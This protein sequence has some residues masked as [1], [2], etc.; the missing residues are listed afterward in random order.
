LFALHKG[1][2]AHA[3][4]FV[5]GVV[6]LSIDLTSQSARFLLPVFPLALAL[7][8]VGVA[9]VFRR[10]WR[11]MQ[12]A[13]A[14]TLLLAL[15]FGLGSETLYAL[16]FLPVVVGL[17]KREAF[18][19]RMAHDYG[20]VSFINR[21]LE[22]RP[23]KVMVF[24]QPV[25]YLRIPFLTGDPM[26]AWPMDPDRLKGPQALLQLFRQQNVRWVVKAPDY[27]EPFAPALQ[28]LEDEGKLRPKF[29]ADSSSFDGY[30]ICGERVPVHAVIMEVATAP[31]CPES[32]VS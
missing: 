31:E 24:F 27:P 21:S 15:L 18:L 16:D 12:L 8:F 7:I 17:E 23:G 25:Y 32:K 2:L 11:V 19:E 13:C 26:I 20:I 22:G 4:A 6:F 9:E 10:G 1:G 5:W 29:S 14:G 3:A 30:R 28:T